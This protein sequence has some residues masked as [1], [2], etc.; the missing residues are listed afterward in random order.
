LKPD[1]FQQRQHIKRTLLA[2]TAVSALIFGVGTTAAI[3]VIDDEG[4]SINL[5]QAAQRIVSLAP[6][7]TELLYAAGAGDNLV[8]V[9]AF[10]DYPEAARSLPIVGSHE[11]LDMER[12]LALSPDLIL[13][14]KSGNPRAS[15]NKLREL[16]LPVF[17]AEPKQLE[18]IPG[19]ITSLATLA[20]TDSVGRI[21]AEEFTRRLRR[22]S[23]AY[24]NKTP[25]RIFYQVWNAP[26]ISV[27]GNELI[28]DMITLCGG[29]NIF[30]DIALVAPKI[31]VEA[32]LAANPDL[33]IGSGDDTERPH[34]LDNWQSWSSL[35]A[36][37]NNRVYSIP[38]F[39]VQRPTPRAL[40]GAEM[41]CNYIDLV[42]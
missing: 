4:N 23:Q 29:E 12:I 19:Y 27:G 9:M 34:W 24:S 39:L 28:N 10:S 20:G 41:M 40:D 5:E 13:A 35:S 32:V 36:I 26:M 37:Q 18:K 11:R 25:V 31:S 16:G 1:F 2:L 33:I 3:E 6:A 14:W 21:A 30:A 42:R 38:P 17:V 15:L 8:G 7:L 22:L